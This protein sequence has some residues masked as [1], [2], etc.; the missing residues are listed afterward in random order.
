[1]NVRKNMAVEI[2]NEVISASAGTGKTY[3]LVNRYI[4]LLAAGMKPETI[5]ALTFTRNAAGEIFDR[6]ISRMSLLVKEPERMKT[7]EYE[8]MGLSGMTGDEML[9]ILR[10]VLLN[11]HLLQI[12]TLDSFF[13]RIIKT[14]SFEFGLSGD[15]EVI[16]EK[17]VEQSKRRVLK[18]ILWNIEFTDK[19]TRSSFLE[20]FKKATFGKEEKRLADI[21]GDFVDSYHYKYLC[22]PEEEMWGIPENIWPDG[23]A[24]L[25]SR[26][27][28]EEEVEKLRGLIEARPLTGK[29]RDKFL[30]FMEMAGNFRPESQLDF[31]NS[32][33]KNL[34][35][36]VPDLEGGNAELTVGTKIRL[37]EAE[38]ECL[39]NLARHIMK[40]QISAQLHKTEG[41]FR[42]VKRYEDFYNMMIRQSGMLTFGDIPFILSPETGYGDNHYAL[43][44]RTPSP[45]D[46]LYIDYR[47][48]SKYDHWLIDEFQDTSYPQWKIIKNLIDEII[49]DGSGRRSFFYVGDTKQA[50]YGWREGEASL[51]KAIY[52]EYSGI[53]D[54]GLKTLSRSFRSGREVIQTVN[55]VFCNLDKI[56]EVPGDV[57]NRWVWEEHSPKTRNK[58]GSPLL[59]GYATLMQLNRIQDEGRVQK[60]DLIARKTRII[61]GKIKEISPFERG[62]STAVLV[63]QNNTGRLIAEYLQ[64]EGI[65]VSIEGQFKLTDNPVVPAFLSL[66]KFAEHPEDNFAWQHLCMTPFAGIMGSQPDV[67]MQVL[68]DV[69][70]SGFAETIQKWSIRLEKEAKIQFDEFTRRR[71]DQFMSAAGIFDHGGGKGCIDFI[72]YIEAYEIPGETA[73]DAVQIMTVYKAKGL[74]YDLVFLPELKSKSIGR[75]DMSGIKVKK[76]QDLS[77]EWLMFMPNRRITELDPVLGELAKDIDEDSC[78]ESLCV[79]YVA[80]TRA[81]EALYM[82]AD[83][84]PKTKSE[85]F[86]HQD[87]LMRTL[88]NRNDQP[89][90]EFRTAYEIGK[91]G[92]YG[93]YPMKHV[94]G[95]THDARPAVNIKFDDVLETQTPS[96]S[97][98]RTVSAG[99]LFEKGAEDARELGIAVHELFENIGW[100][101]DADLKGICSEWRR[102]NGFSDKTAA[103]AI[104]IF[105]S[106]IGSK[107]LRSSLEKPAGNPELWREKRFELILEGRWISGQ[108]DRVTILRDQNGITGA[109]I[110]DYKTDHVSSEEDMENSLESYA[111]QLELYRKALALLLNIPEKNIS[112]SLAFLRTGKVNGN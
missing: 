21:L 39:L 68:D 46:R 54:I 8:E 70:Q 32:F 26:V 58:D 50:I 101:E 52:D 77:P 71:M 82:I 13:V 2:K 84:P 24:V 83:P 111:P 15:F 94:S 93:K 51:F 55:N 63:L 110:L 11:M 49:Q 5:V 19:D 22:A 105:N 75:A 87:V 95:E 3:Q 29:Q 102:S 53:S 1:M 57:K 45:D 14:F 61:V 31:D 67:S 40:C 30:E 62:L 18:N 10:R 17:M 80:M 23:S 44:S 108:F 98:K 6:I 96:G 73:E 25:S 88:S 35:S 91:D 90:A 4:S 7:P 89:D 38:C 48:D 109:V 106:S 59:D 107:E 27:N 85:S 56:D 99:G 36:I 69:Y 97:E 43:T 76:R 65:K 79:L 104:D 42:L 86:Y 66:F 9:A 41:I 47:L 103:A 33:N 92:W 74:E 64:A 72:E 34:F 78:Y 60:D 112:A 100:L 12:G 37:S 20:E 81:A 16:D 28:P